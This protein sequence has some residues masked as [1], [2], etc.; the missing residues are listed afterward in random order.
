MNWESKNNRPIVLLDMDDVITDCLSGVVKTYNELYNA[1]FKPAD[2]NVWDLS[3]FFNT[4]RATVISLFRT[5]NFFEELEP[6][7]GSVSAIKELVKSTKYDVYIIT[8]TSDD[9]GIELN[10]KSKWLK[11]YIPEF[12]TKRLIACDDKYII[13]GD[14]IVDDKIANLQMCEENMCCILM[15]STTNKECKNYIRI[16]SLQE[17]PQLLDE[18]FYSPG[19]IR[20]FKKTVLPKLIKESNK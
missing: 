5:D 10:Q 18:I 16:K 11:K 17:L 13:R 19:G 9:E 14:I 7:Q 15:D 12:N 1:N 8:A 2:C 6:R 3:E 4:S 20:T